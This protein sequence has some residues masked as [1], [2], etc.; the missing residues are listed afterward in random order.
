[1]SRMAKRCKLGSFFIVLSQGMHA[2]EGRVESKA[3]VDFSLAKEIREG[4]KS[5]QVFSTLYTKKNVR[6]KGRSRSW[7]S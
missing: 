2:L 4:E 5:L 3:V 1:M 7:Q 6:K